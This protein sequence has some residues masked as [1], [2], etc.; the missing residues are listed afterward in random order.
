MKRAS[1]LGLVG[2]LA[3]GPA[4]ADATPSVR[5]A[6]HAGFGRI[7]FDFTERVPF[8]TAADGDRVTVQFEGASA[9]PDPARMPRNVL[10]FIGRD[11]AAEI[12]VA[13]GARVRS[14][15]VGNRVV[16]D[17]LD[18]A[19]IRAQGRQTPARAAIRPGARGP[20]AAQPQPA[21]PAPAAAEAPPAPAA[22]ASAAPAAPA[23]AASVPVIV[24]TLA[25]PPVETAPAKAE[26]AKAEQPAPSAPRSA[27]PSV[28]AAAAPGP[29]S[30]VTT[31]VA[32]DEPTFLA[33]F[34]AGVGAAA[35]RRGSGGVVVFDER[36]PLDLSRL[37]E[38]PAL[39]QATVQLLPAA[40]MV[41]IPMPAAAQLQLQREPDGWR[42]QIALTAGAAKSIVPTLSPGGLDLASPVPGQVVVVPDDDGGHALL[43]GTLNPASGVASGV[44]VQRRTPE[45]TVAPSWLGVAVEPLADRLQLQLSKAGFTLAV[46]GAVLAASGADLN[47]LSDSTPSTRRFD[48][49][50]DPSDVLLRRMQAQ[51][52]DAATSAPRDRLRKRLAAAQT[53]VALGLS[54]E[55]HALLT[56]AQ[57]D[58]P[59]TADADVAGLSAIAAMLLGR[60]D[61]APALDDPRLT[62]T[63]EISLWRA[64]RDLMLDENA[65]G[66]ADVAAS[67]LPLIMSYPPALRGRLL[68]LAAEA[69]ALR[70]PHAVVDAMLAALPDDPLLAYARAIRLEAKGDADSALLVYD[71]LGAGR[72]R[73]LR[74]RAASRATELRLSLGRLAPADAAEELETQLLAWRGDGRER[75]LRLRAAELR[76]QAGLWRAALDG[77]REVDAA[78]P[79][80]RPAIR[81]RMTGVLQAM[82]SAGPDRDV[83]PLTLV[84]ISEDYAEFLPAGPAG[85][86]LA[87]LLAD[88]LVA[89]DLPQRAGPVLDR[90]M[91]AAPAGVARATLGARL[92]ALRL[93]DGDLQGAA[94]ALTVSNAADLP[95]ALAETRT[96]ILARVRAA[97]G[98]LPAAT[99]ALAA[100][101]SAAADDLRANLLAASGDWRG[102]LV[103]LSDLSAKVVPAEGA[104]TD[105]Q[106]NVLLRQAGAAAQ[107]SD[108]DRLRVLREREGPRMKGGAGGDVFRLLTTEPIR[109]TADLP[110]A[111]GEMALARALP[112]QLQGLTSR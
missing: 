69:I 98:D 37:R 9:V 53:M 3:A 28:A 92:A 96:L 84:A 61:D 32:A 102:A 97:Q 52:A 19:P 54:V 2:L 88:K 14:G 23:S 89:L 65:P 70:G 5:A 55:A 111:A 60:V 107:A 4:L 22:P 51:V 34:P 43:V 27:A 7:V 20:A 49:P 104:L 64:V 16:I 99:A 82:L 6:S 1:V 17:I 100:L 79:E 85:A 112:G 78:F 59:Q 90:L 77:L 68:P 109:A 31:P 110:R 8:E 38:I 25:K 81:A 75:T 13:P 91:R 56:N 36:R 30:L 73:L 46:P 44:A 101:G 35:F 45:F 39:A 58:E 103:A 50:N 87:A 86:V 11:G 47:S 18:A 83:A 93:D 106:R 41:R 108:F 74:A 21:A 10:S 40:T 66:A 33:P 72:D 57:A 12:T 76:T 105:A 15:R 67:T 26:L 63:D 48:F 62:G 71:A 24:E 29:V 94:A 42:I 80:Q 95:A